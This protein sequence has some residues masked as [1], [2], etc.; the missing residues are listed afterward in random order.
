MWSVLR[1]IVRAF[2]LIELLVVIA[3]IAILAGMLLPALAAARE[4]ARRSSCLNQLNQMGKGLESY[5]GDYSQYFPC[6]S[7]YGAN[8]MAYR[9]PYPYLFCNTTWQ[10]D[11]W[12]QDPRLKQQ[13]SSDPTKWRIRTTAP[14]AAGG[15]RY[16][17][18]YGANTRSRTI[19]I[20][21]KTESRTWSSTREA[22][23]EG[24]LNFAPQGLGYL[25][26]CGYMGDAR[27]FYCASVGGNMP[28]P[29]G[30]W[31]TWNVAEDAATSVTHLKRAGGFD[32]RTV[33]YGDWSWLK[34][35]NTSYDAIRAVYSDY[36]YRN[37]PAVVS[38]VADYEG[39]GTRTFP[40]L[41]VVSTETRFMMRDTKPRVG[42][43][44]ACPAFKTQKILAGRAV[45]A[46][47]FGRH[48]DA[49][50]PTLYPDHNNPPIGDGAYAHRDGYNVLYGDWHARWY[51]DPQERFIWWPDL[52]PEYLPAGY[53]NYYTD[54]NMSHN[55]GALGIGYWQFPDGSDCE[56]WTNYDFG[57][58]KQNTSQAAWHLLDVAVG[59][60]V[61]AD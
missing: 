9:S 50:N 44:A 25:L 59:V 39:S 19:F 15:T 26:A 30:L 12:Y 51:G 11:G 37:G 42:V 3:I 46:D 41:P 38:A 28:K 10:D 27:L 45:V 13:Y 57:G 32:A 49:G 18:H 52:Q 17:A 48:N 40:S 23:E 36:A 47:S 4:K 16:F 35:N 33:M 55:T 8:P 43:Q 6:M 21:D 24:E 20:G 56:P 5:C 54:Y 34:E 7:A 61:D 53:A 14:C 31:A 1:R 58:M 29:Y 2:T 22:A 60:D